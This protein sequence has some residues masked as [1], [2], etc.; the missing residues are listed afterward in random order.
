M[1]IN[2]KRMV[3]NFTEL[4]SISSLS[5]KEAGVATRLERIFKLMGAAV[6]MDNAGEKIQ[7]D[8]GNLVVKIKGTG[9]G[10]PFLLSAH[11]DTVGPA[12]DIKPQ[13]HSDRVTS[14]GTTVLGADC[15]AGIAII[16]ETVKVLEEMR[17]PH[18]PLELV[19]TISEEM[20]LMGAKFLDYSKLKARRGLIFDNEKPLD[21]V[22]TSAPAADKMDIKVYGLAA[23]AG[24]APEKGISAIKIVSSAIAGMKLGRIDSETTANIGFINGG[25]AVNIVP[26]LVELSGEARSHNLEK[27]RRQTRHMEDC[28]KKAVKKMRVR[29]RGKTFSPRY[30]FLL[31]HKFPNLIINSRDPVLKIIEEAMKDQGLKMKAMASG[32]G[33]DANIMYGHGISAPILGTGMREVHTTHEYLDLKDFFGC[34]RLTLGIIGRLTKNNDPV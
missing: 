11:M 9:G 17:L 23:H 10:E 31:E 32:G 13:V 7:G 34:A 24:V 4:A 12:A 20:A 15:K 22:I 26:P 29:S 16:I 18:P 33:T 28:L 14:D 3:R 19:F 6:Y 2:E 25:N 30:D 21:C 1:S 27:L 5:G 8:S